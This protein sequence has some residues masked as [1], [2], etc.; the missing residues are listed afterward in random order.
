MWRSGVGKV[1]NCLAIGFLRHLDIE[2][3]D[4]RAPRP[5]LE[6]VMLAGHKHN[7]GISNQA[8]ASEVPQDPANN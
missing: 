5:V 3:E 1:R 6:P 2:G 8:R 4:Q 7:L